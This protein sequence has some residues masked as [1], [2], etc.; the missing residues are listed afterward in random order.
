[1]A[2][3]CARS[4]EMKLFPHGILLHAE[5]KMISFKAFDEMKV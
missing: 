5:T 3:Y 1:M 4:C 2:D